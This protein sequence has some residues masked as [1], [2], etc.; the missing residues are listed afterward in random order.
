ML[1]NSR[2]DAKVSNLYTA[3]TSQQDVA[4][5]HVTMNV[6]VLIEDT[7]LVVDEV[8]WTVSKYFEEKI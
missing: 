4:C 3:V 5:L 6:A 7:W 1:N 8:V 2:A